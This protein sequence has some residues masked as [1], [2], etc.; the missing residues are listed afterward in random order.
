MI[1]I[2]TIRSVDSAHSRWSR[3]ETLYFGISVA[4]IED[5]VPMTVGPKKEKP[6]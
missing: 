2:E 5:D 6:T 1:C 4:A 3:S